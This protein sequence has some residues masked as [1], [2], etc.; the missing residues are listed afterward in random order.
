MLS[1]VIAAALPPVLLL[2]LVMSAPAG[3]T[4]PS[5]LITPT[6]GV[7]LPLIVDGHPTLTPT[8]TP[9][10]TPTITATRTQTSIPTMTSTPTQTP[11]IDPNVTA[12][13]TAT[14]TRNPAQ[15]A[16]EYPTVCIPPPPPD[17][18]CGDITFR[19]FTVL[20]PD[21]H[22]FDTDND[23]VGCEGA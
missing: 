2:A 17:L 4:N 9:S 10:L 3:A 1:R 19:N 23:G 21:R 7:Y 8:L 15:C 12:T 14:P 18:N 13:F 11:T 5:Q 20:E 16:A 22:N 6:A